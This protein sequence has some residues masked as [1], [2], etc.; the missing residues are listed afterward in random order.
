MYSK[1]KMVNGWKIEKKD[2]KESVQNGIQF[3]KLLAKQV[4]NLAAN[5]ERIRC[6]IIDP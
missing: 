4:F 2:E 5:K 1:E 6:C 3:I